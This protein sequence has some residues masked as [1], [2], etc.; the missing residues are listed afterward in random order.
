MMVASDTQTTNIQPSQETSFLR[1]IVHSQQ[2]TL[3][4]SQEKLSA[5]I[6]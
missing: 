5:I 1:V 6:E 2:M 4:L 3:S